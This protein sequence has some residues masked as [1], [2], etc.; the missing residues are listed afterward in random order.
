MQDIQSE[1]A[2]LQPWFH[3]LHLPDGFQTA[4]EHPLGDFP[5]FKWVDIEKSIPQNLSRFS[6]LDIGCNAGF[7]SFE[8]AR[9]GAHVT[10]I[11][12]NDHYLM[13]ARWASKQFHLEHE[14]NFR[15]MQVYDLAHTSDKYDIVWFMGVF[16]HL[17][18]PFL[19]LDIVSRITKKTLVFQSMTIPNDFVPIYSENI[20][21][22]DRNVLNEKG[23]PKIAFI[24]NSIDGDPTNW[25]IPDHGAIMAM[26]RSSGF[27]VTSFPTH[28]VY[29]CDKFDNTM[30][31]EDV[32]ELE[33]RAA[34]GLTQIDNY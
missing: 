23:W 22:F 5:Y 2:A 15:K 20:D 28:E 13:Q 31:S 19:A 12:I 26:L 18:Y 8:L 21:L 4:P 33:Y 9:R 30:D 25:W 11:D 24:E 32:R 3:N 1:I 27:K 29:I 17:R 7:Y 10:A 34:T 6:I 16:Y 14:I